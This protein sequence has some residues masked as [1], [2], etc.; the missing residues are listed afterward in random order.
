MSNQHRRPLKVGLIIHTF[1]GVM[2][3]RTATWADIKALPSMIVVDTV[4][5]AD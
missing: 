2:D 5:R 4:D 1:E 3:E